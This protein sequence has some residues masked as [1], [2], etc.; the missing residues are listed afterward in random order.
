LK[1]DLTN[2]PDAQEQSRSQR[3]KRLQ[4]DV[5]E[6][7]PVYVLDDGAQII[8]KADYDALVTEQDS[9]SEAHKQSQRQLNSSEPVELE[10]DEQ[11][12][13]TT[14]AQH[15]AGTG[16][17]IKKRKATKISHESDEETRAPASISSTTTVPKGKKKRKIKLSF[18]T[19]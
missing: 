1:G 13:L 15:V 7:D 8:S 17:R 12:K 5:A 6:D 16:P 10:V 2:V 4:R 19:E 3:P 14:A 9:T 18:D 11:S